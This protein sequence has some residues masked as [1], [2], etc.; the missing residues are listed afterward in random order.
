MAD[1]QD[2]TF[3]LITEGTIGVN[4]LKP[5]LKTTIQTLLQAKA[6]QREMERVMGISRHATRAYQQRFATDAANWPGVAT[7]P[8]AL[9]AAQT[10]PPR[11]PAV[12]TAATSPC[13]P[14][15]EFIEAQLRLKRNA[16]PIYQD[17]VD[18]RGFAGHCNSVRRFV[19][20]LRR[21]AP[22]QFDRRSFL[23]GEDAPTRVPGSERYRK[24][25]LFVASLHYSRA[26][27]RCVVWISS[28]RAGPNCT[29]SRLCPAIEYLPGGGGTQ[30]LLGSRVSGHAS[31]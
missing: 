25:R 15:R 24:P 27:L 22:E 4:V 11:P 28:Q 29:S 30:T 17:L 8:V 10:A 21:K 12:V 26:R 3:T 16:M 23:L 7:D 2:V 9:A 31:A 13:E 14:H 20:K 5:H 19:V 6:S 1:R 18:Q